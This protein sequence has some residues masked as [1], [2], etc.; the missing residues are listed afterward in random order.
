MKFMHLS[1]L[2]IGKKIYGH[3]MLEDQRAVLEQ[4]LEIADRTRPDGI[5]IAGD[6]YDKAVPQESGIALFDYFLTELNRRNMPVFVVSGNHDSGQRL[7]FGGIIM[8]KE[9]IWISGIYNGT[10]EK[11]RMED[12]FGPVNIYLMPF[13]KPMA[14]RKYYKADTYEEAVKAVLG[15][16]EI[17]DAER[18]VLVA[19]QFVTNGAAL[20]E[21]CDSE[22]VFIGGLDHVDCSVFDAFDYTALGHL[23][24]PQKVGRDT[25]RYAGSPLKYSFSECYHKKSVVIAELKEKGSCQTERIPI[26]P[27]HDMRELKGPLEA[28]KNPQNYKKGDV[29]DYIRAV[30]TDE[31]EL[32]A[33]LETLRKIYPNILR[34]DFENSRTKKEAELEFEADIEE[35]DDLELFEEFYS[36]QN[37][38]KLSQEQ[39]TLVKE[40]LN[41][42]GK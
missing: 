15:H 23:H 11:I 18:N 19:H 28:L 13:I 7:H 32:Y 10:L 41:G 8:R 9:N 35:K 31:E 22:T 14:V 4:I 38:R 42:N 16:T 21:Q 33:P 30:L 12:E 17:N 3:P 26:K 1:D 20:P 5:L 25:V 37:G 29:N 34:M 36:M 27:L 24:G 40:L 39:E 6:V 2:H